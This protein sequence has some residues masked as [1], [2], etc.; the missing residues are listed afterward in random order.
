MAAAVSAVDVD[1]PAAAC[2][3]VSRAA[4]EM[5]GGF[6]E[7]FRPAWFEDVDLC[8]RIRNHGGRIRYEPGAK[9]LHHGSYSLGHLSRQDFLEYFHGNQIRY[10]R[11]HY[12]PAAASRAKHLIVIGLLIRSAAFLAAAFF[13]RPPASGESRNASAKACWKTARSI[14]KLSE[15]LS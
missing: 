8:R 12:G 2:L 14:S 13:A 1:Q 10:F 11:K 15:R 9:F 4:L 6:D 7:D 3:M 5:I